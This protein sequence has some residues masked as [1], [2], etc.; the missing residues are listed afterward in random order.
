MIQK[1]KGLRFYYE[2]G[3]D[4]LK[5]DSYDVEDLEYKGHKFIW[6]IAPQ[7]D[8][9]GTDMHVYLCESCGFYSIFLNEDYIKNHSSCILSCEEY[10]IKKLLE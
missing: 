2:E 5:C 4:E 7:K 10:S 1:V 6:A 9:Y 3:G 8:M